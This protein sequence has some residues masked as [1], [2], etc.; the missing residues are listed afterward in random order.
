MNLTLVLQ[1]IHKMSD[2]WKR[3]RSLGINSSQHLVRSDPAKIYSKQ[4]DRGN[5]NRLPVFKERLY[6]VKKRHPV[7]L[8]YFL[9]LAKTAKVCKSEMSSQPLGG[10]VTLLWRNFPCVFTQSHQPNMRALRGMENS[11]QLCKLET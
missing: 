7:S 1:G 5:Q 10:A 9:M 2:Q 4:N 11:R 6:R 8:N 3:C